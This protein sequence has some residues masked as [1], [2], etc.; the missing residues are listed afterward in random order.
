MCPANLADA[1][2]S[3][4]ADASTSPE[5]DVLAATADPRRLRP[6]EAPELHCWCDRTSFIGPPVSPGRLAR[7]DERALLGVGS[8]SPIASDDQRVHE[9][10]PS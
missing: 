1:L 8:K 2:V 6:E 9:L 10:L 4:Y 5:A 3:A 7:L